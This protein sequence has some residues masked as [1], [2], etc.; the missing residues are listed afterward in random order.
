M[1]FFKQRGREGRNPPINSIFLA[2]V[3]ELRNTSDYGSEKLHFVMRQAGFSVSRR[4][5]Q[6]IL[7]LRKG[8]TEPL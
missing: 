2:K 6:Q 4:K 7:D 5:I 1:R 3:I 8:L